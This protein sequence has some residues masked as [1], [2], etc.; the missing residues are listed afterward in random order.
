VSSAIRS[1]VERGENIPTLLVATTFALALGRTMS[2]LM[3]ADERPTIHI[4]RFL[5]L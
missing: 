4:R 1:T 3:G 2:R 5:F